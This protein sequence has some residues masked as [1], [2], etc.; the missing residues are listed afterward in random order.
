MCV[1][2]FATENAQKSHVLSHL[3]LA[4]ANG[5]GPGFVSWWHRGLDSWLDFF[6]L[7]LGESS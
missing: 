6:F 4:A 3:C 1:N 5:A 7:A 2:I